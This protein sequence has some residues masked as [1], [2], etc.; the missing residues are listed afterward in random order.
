M[1][2]TEYNAF[3]LTI[4][5]SRYSFHDIQHII[6]LTKAELSFDLAIMLYPKAMK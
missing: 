3:Q 1:I 5:M 6:N 2:A 4:K